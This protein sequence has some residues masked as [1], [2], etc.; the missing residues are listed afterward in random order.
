M[1]AND[2]ALCALCALG[3]VF[4]S[5]PIDK[6]SEPC[7]ASTVTPPRHQFIDDEPSNRPA[8]WVFDQTSQMRLVRRTDHRSERILKHTRHT[9]THT[10]EK[11]LMGHMHPR[12]LWKM[13]GRK[14]KVL[15]EAGCNTAEW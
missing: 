6:I 11:Y 9:H 3:F 1:K 10:A 7:A 12:T 15:S 5:Q 8:P 2:R 13:E 14:D 4:R